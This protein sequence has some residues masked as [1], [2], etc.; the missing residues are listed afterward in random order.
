MADIQQQLKLGSE[1]LDRQV[2]L[3][4]NININE[5]EEDGNKNL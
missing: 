3:Q 2:N 1:N 4:D 5:E